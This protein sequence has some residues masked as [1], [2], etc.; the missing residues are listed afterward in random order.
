MNSDAAREQAAEALAEVRGRQLAVIDAYHVPVWYFPAM[1]ALLVGSTAA[2]E[3]GAAVIGFL[4][5]SLGLTALVVTL[6]SRLRV[7]PAGLIGPRTWLQIV[8]F[9]A[10]AI[11][12]TLAFWYLLSSRGLP[13]PRTL[14]SLSMAFS[15]V[16]GGPLLVRRL[17]RD[18]A[19][20]T[21]GG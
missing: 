19:G 15:L 1:A 16:I 4:A 17:R 7:L 6:H 10:V 14:S 20:R 11:G 21:R 3:T 13:Y 5:Y 18:L 12:L 8:V 2:I 9:L